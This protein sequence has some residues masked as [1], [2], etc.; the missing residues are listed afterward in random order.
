MTQTQ[1]NPPQSMTEET[2]SETARWFGVRE[3]AASIVGIGLYMVVTWFTGF[4]QLS[5]G[6]GVE[7]RP[8][9]VIP[10]VFGFAY[11]PMVGFLVGAL[12]NTAADQILYGSFTAV[13]NW[14]RASGL[15]AGAVRAVPQV[16]PKLVRPGHRVVVSALGILIGMG[17]AA[18]SSMAV[19]SEQ[20]ALDSCFVVPTTFNDAWTTFVPAA[21]ANIITAVILV[22]VLLYNMARLDLQNVNWSR[23]GLLW[24]FIVVVTISAALPIALLGFFLLQDISG[25]DTGTTDT[26]MLVRIGGTIVVTLLFTVANATLVAQELNRPLL[27]LAESARKMEDESSRSTKPRPC[28]QRRVRTKSAT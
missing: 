27:Q 11:G 6:L 24:R 18:F 26:I 9:I 14:Q 10:I 19:C 12:G 8:S 1:L 7:I 23:S 25:A 3:L 15:S 21:Q 5:A 2:Q 17:F 13:G 20:F 28:E 16:L 22:P 4:A